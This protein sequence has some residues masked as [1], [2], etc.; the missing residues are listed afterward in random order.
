MFIL[1]FE[2]A[3]ATEIYTLGMER[4]KEALGEGP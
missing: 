3:N 1:T 2:Q 4:L